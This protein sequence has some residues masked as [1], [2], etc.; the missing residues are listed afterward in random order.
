VRKLLPQVAAS[1]LPEEP[2]WYART[3][4]AG[5]NFE[6]VTFASEDLKRAGFYQHNAKRASLQKQVGGVDTYLASLDMTI[7]IQLFDATGLAR[8]VQLINK[9]NFYNLTTRRYTDP[10]VTEA[11]RDPAV[12]TLQLRLADVFG[13]NGMISVVICWPREAEVREIDTWLM[14]C[15]VPGRKV[16]H[17]VLREIVRYARGAGIHK[18]IGIYRPTDRNKPVIDHYAK[19]GFTKVGEEDSGL[20]RWELLVEGAEPES[21]PMKVVQQGF[22]VSKENV[23]A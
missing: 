4:A 14:R 20:T 12:F 6:A 11:E 2:A 5:G 3:L 9:S 8:I 16:E 22:A 7:T 10:E 21:A 17:M 13:D 15:R 19:L 1:E 23:I 18:L